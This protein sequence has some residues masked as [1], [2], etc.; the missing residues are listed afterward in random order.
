MRQTILF[1]AI[2]SKKKCPLSRQRCLAEECALWTDDGLRHVHS[3]TYTGVCR[4]GRC[5]LCRR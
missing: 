2:A 5:G 1:A 3:R 4:V